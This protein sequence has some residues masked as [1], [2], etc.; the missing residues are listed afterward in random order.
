MY[1][2]KYSFIDEL[3]S[4]APVE[5]LIYVRNEEALPIILMHG[6]PGSIIEMLK[7]IDP[8]TNPTAYGGLMNRLGYTNYV[9]QGGDWGAII[10]DLMGVQKL[11][12]LIGLHTNMPGAVPAD[13]EKAMRNTRVSS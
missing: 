13:I 1:E 10:A 9:A 3:R 12:G 5:G 4:P 6:W 7:I 8:L 11:K 2:W